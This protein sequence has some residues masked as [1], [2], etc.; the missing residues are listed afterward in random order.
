MNSCEPPNWIASGASPQLGLEMIHIWRA[1]LD[2]DEKAVGSLEALLSEDERTRANRFHFAND[3]RRFTVARGILRSIVGAY[4]RLSSA[5]LE[6][7]YGSNGKPWIKSDGRDESLS[8]NLSHS[9]ETVLYA[10][11]RNHQ[12]GVD[13]EHL[14]RRVEYLE[15]AQ[16]FFAPEEI[17]SITTLSDDQQCRRFFEIWTRK[18]A[19]LKAL[20]TGLSMPLNEFEVVSVERNSYD[21][22]GSADSGRRIG[23]SFCQFEPQPGYI[24]AIATDTGYGQISWWDWRDGIAIAP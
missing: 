8:F 10:F 3:R 2:L 1:S 13:V 6:F 4:L 22:A 19:Y 7:S 16:E 12:I 20:G 5:N 21:D 15:I 9:G 11:R 17:Q 18:E 14:D 24:A 23:W